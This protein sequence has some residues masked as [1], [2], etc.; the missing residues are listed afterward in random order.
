V[1]TAAPIAIASQ[2]VGFACAQLTLLIAASS[3]ALLSAGKITAFKNFQKL[4]PA[5]KS[6]II[7]LASCSIEGVI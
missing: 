5:C 1:P 6:A 7:L 3:D 2:P 4:I